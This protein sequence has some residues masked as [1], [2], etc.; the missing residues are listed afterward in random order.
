MRYRERVEVFRERIG[1]VIAGSGL[2]HSKFAASIGVDRSTLS[3]LLS[4]SNLR[5]PRADTIASIAEKY[6]VSVDWL[7]GLTAHG[8]LA[9]DVLTE[10]LEFED[11]SES[12]ANQKL[13]QWHQE[14]SNYKIRYIPATLPDLCKTESVSTYEFKRYGLGKTD[15]SIRD[16][17]VLLI[18]QRREESEMEVCQSIQDIE[19]FALGEG[20]WSDLSR[21]SR[22]EQLEHMRH[23]VEE[24][25]PRFRWF[26]FDS[27]KIYSAA[28]T[29]FGPMRA[30]I[31][32]GQSYLVLNGTEHIRFFSR[33]FDELIRNAVIQP[34]EIA[35]YL[36][37]LKKKI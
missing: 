13:L 16:T 19:G 25:Y 26:L 30:V 22:L 28:F 23:L 35:N 6:Q 1:E 37:N 14:A 33:R 9:A 17:H 24:L 12:S 18:Q 2:N 5:L 34:N 10:P 15:Q 36:N 29:L 11:F 20:I 4:D 8:I 32:V 7:L 3:Q 27:R 31:F 21:E